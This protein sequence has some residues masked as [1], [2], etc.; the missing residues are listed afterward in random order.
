M[1]RIGACIATVLAL[2]GCAVEEARH[3]YS[4]EV[5]QLAEDAWTHMLEQSPY[6][7]NRQGIRVT[8]IPDLS[9][10]EAAGNLEWARS[11]LERIDGI[12][13][14]ALSHADAL[15]LEC[16]RWDYQIAIEGEPF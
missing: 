14:E 5:A 11:M 7:Q 9:E 2:S 12:P 6:L 15:T 13:L 4:A 10:E 1:R 16:L 3:D 8:E